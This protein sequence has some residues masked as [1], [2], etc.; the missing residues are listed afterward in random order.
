MAPS[1]AG[2]FADY[3]LPVQQAAQLA[4]A[5]AGVPTAAPVVTETDPAWLGA[6]FTVMPRVDGHLIG[7]APPFDRWLRGLGPER[8]AELH[9]RVLETL[10]LIHDADADAAAAAGV[11]VRDD[12][13]ELAYWDEYLRWSAGGD[14]LPE[15]VD[16]LDWCRRHA[17]ERVD[18]PRVLRWG[19]VRLGNI[20]FGDDL[21]P[22]AVLDWDMAAVGVPEHDVAWFTVLDLVLTTLTGRRVE[23]FPDRDGVVARYEE[24]ARR[25]LDRFDWYETLALLRSTAILARIGVLMRRDGEEPAMP[26][27]GSPMLDLLRSRTSGPPPA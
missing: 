23:G 25:S 11:P 27:E 9:D 19:D 4:A 8:Q 1:P 7:E 6:P 20:V 17:P 2:T 10:A 14:P 22:R 5:A 12:A 18:P 15:L 13:A 26:V 24:L 16:A 21:R 3:D